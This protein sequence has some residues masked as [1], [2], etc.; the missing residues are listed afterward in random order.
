MRGRSRCETQCGAIAGPCGLTTATAGA[1]SCSF[2][3]VIPRRRPPIDLHRIPHVRLPMVGDRK[4]DASGAST[5]H[6]GYVHTCLVSQGPQEHSRDI[7]HH[8][9]TFGGLVPAYH[10]APSRS[11]IC[12]HASCCKRPVG[13]AHAAYPF[14]LRCFSAGGSLRKRSR[15]K[16]AD[17][18]ESKR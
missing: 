5:G 9:T 4:F 2:R 13:K 8:S 15:Q 16:P 3:L 11:D 6:P 14:R 17:S 10:I 1:P 12:F 7:P 18:E